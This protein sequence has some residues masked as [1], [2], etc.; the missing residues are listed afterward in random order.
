MMR[1]AD[2]YDLQL[3][4]KVVV[5]VDHI[6][7]LTYKVNTY[8]GQRILM[9][10]DVPPRPAHNGTLTVGVHSIDRKYDW[11]YPLSKLQLPEPEDLI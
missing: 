1:T 5:V 6:D 3:G 7:L 2:L 10:V 9:I 4:D 11:Y 8:I